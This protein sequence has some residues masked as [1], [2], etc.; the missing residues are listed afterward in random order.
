M[1]DPTT[2]EPVLHPSDLP[3]DPS[4]IAI[5]GILQFRFPLPSCDLLTLFQ[6][7][8]HSNEDSSFWEI[9]EEKFG[10]VSQGTV[11]ENTASG[12]HRFTELDQFHRHWQN[13]VSILSGREFPDPVPVF[14]S[15]ASFFPEIHSSLWQ[16]FSPARLSIPS[17]MVVRNGDRFTGCIHVKVE[18]EEQFESLTP[19][20]LLAQGKQLRDLL[21]QS[22]PI[23]ETVPEGIHE[24]NGRQHD[25]DKT[26][27]HSIQAVSNHQADKVVVGFSTRIKL[28]QA[29]PVPG[30][31]YRLRYSYPSCVL[32]AQSLATGETFFGATPE[33]LLRTNGTSIYTDALAGSIRRDGDPVRDRELGEELLASRKNLCEHAYVV[34]YLKEKLEPL[35]SGLD[36]PPSPELRK[37]ENIQHLYTPVR[38]NLDYG[39]SPFR[40]LGELHP[41]PSVGGIPTSDAL[42][43]IRSLE[44]FDR[45]YY[46]GVL[47]WMDVTGSGDFAVGLR[48]GLAKGSDLHLFA[49]AGIVED[50]DPGEEYEEIQM[51]LQP[52]LRTVNRHS[53]D[54]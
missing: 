30:M 27:R 17:R 8:N 50:S 12:S 22:G 44:S 25:W 46:A 23:E 29:V 11:L 52:L 7:W 32:F 20:S 18:D 54:D 3:E 6:Q 21:N 26:I 48:S 24:R 4:E 2:S 34:S 36:S 13:R 14:L 19:A 28:Q 31:L 5:P 37:L 38:A 53:R 45:G 42:Q 43:L 10:F 40:I 41:T 51:K 47:G 39:I 16:G 33:W 49:G 35:V 1:S 9:P 15:S